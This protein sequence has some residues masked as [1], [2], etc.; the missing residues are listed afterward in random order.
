MSR[1]VL[2]PELDVILGLSRLSSQGL[3]LLYQQG[4]VA[5]EGPQGSLPGPSSPLPP[6]LCKPQ[7]S[8]AMANLDPCSCVW[9][10]LDLHRAAACRSPSTHMSKPLNRHGETGG[11]GSS[12]IASRRRA[13]FAPR[14]QLPCFP[15]GAGKLGGFYRFRVS[16]QFADTSLAFEG[17]D[18]PAFAAPTRPRLDPASTAG[19]AASVVFARSSGI[20]KDT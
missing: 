17:Q 19:H 14:P 11:G 7:C 9:C 12:A 13:G 10:L 16:L 6:H 1:L 5:G 4:R 20:S 15:D 2:G 3:R 8:S 18:R